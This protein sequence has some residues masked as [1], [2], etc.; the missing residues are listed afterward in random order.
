MFSL[1]LSLYLSF[2][3]SSL[4][5]S[6]SLS[7]SV[8]H[9]LFL[10]ISLVLSL[11]LSHSLFLSLSLSHTLTYTHLLLCKVEFCFSQMHSGPC[12]L[13]KKKKQHSAHYLTCFL[14][15]VKVWPKENKTWQSPLDNENKKHMSINQNDTDT[16]NYKK[17]TLMKVFIFLALLHWGCPCSILKWNKIIVLSTFRASET[18]WG[19]LCWLRVNNVQK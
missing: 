1:S 15:C 16:Y 8:Y 18:S 12:L 11:P 17:V 19:G 10:T 6:L 9:S 13:V 7:P 3:L 14:H 5:L 4:F 2:L